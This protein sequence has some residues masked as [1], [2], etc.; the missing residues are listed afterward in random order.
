M[1]KVATQAGT[2]ETEV[3]RAML[4][5]TWETM[6]RKLPSEVKIMAVVATRRPYSSDNIWGMVLRPLFYRGLA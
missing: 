5:R 1:V 3:T 4:E 6:L 2:L